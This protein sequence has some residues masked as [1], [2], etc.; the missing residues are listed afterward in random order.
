MRTWMV[1]TLACAVLGC[2]QA[3]IE[4]DSP[5]PKSPPI[6]AA[7]SNDRP[8]ATL[9]AASGPGERTVPVNITGVI[10]SL[11]KDMIAL[12]ARY[13][14]LADSGAIRTGQ[15][16]AQSAIY[17]LEYF[18]NC[19]DAERTGFADAGASAAAVR[20]VIC[21]LS[22]RTKES[23]MQRLKPHMPPPDLTLPAL[24]VGLWSQLHAGK[25]PTPGFE[26]AMRKSLD[27]HVEMVRE[28]ERR[29][30]TRGNVKVK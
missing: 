21:P 29:A 16:P 28:I 19:R 17:G 14:E 11:K 1:F 6:A 3:R 5:A 9:S 27:R 13:P 4:N 2:Q 26:A 15:I 23:D 10:E 8:S 12:G 25:N 30:R 20:F 18:H 7:R 24:G 22:D